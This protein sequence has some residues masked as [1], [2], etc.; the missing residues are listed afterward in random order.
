MEKRKKGR[1]RER[2]NARGK[3]GERKEEKRKVRGTTYEHRLLKAV[4]VE[5]RCVKFCF[6]ADGWGFWRSGLFVWGNDK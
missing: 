3:E 4:G 2:E 6:P 1:K 5:T